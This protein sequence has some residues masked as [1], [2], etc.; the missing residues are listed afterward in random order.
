MSLLTFNIPE[1]IWVAFNLLVLIIVLRQ[2][3]WKRVFKVLDARQEMAAKTVQDAE[4]AKSLKAEMEQLR[5]SLDA[6]LDAKTVAQMQEARTRAGKEYDRIVSEAEAKASLIVSA[7]TAKARQERDAI[8]VEAR[9]QVAS[10]A[11]EAVGVL[12]HANID[13]ERNRRLIEDF[14]SEGDMSA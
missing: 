13:S 5:A 12:L 3:L 9:G 2:I 11:M 10:T 4:D 8:L 7:A 14:L 6:E 1:W